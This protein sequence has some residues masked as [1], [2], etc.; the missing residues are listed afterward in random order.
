MKKII[1]AAALAL[2]SACSNV[3]TEANEEKVLNAKPVFFGS[4]GVYDQPVKGSEWVAWSTQAIPVNMQPEQHT[5]ELN[6]LMTSDGVPL[7][8]DASVVTQ[9]TD[10]VGLIKRFGTGWYDNNLRTEL[11]SYIRDAVKKHGMN[12]TAITSSAA[13]SIDA[14][15]SRRI[16]D[17]L[18]RTKF[19]V[20]LVRFTIGRANPPDS[21]K[22]QRI[23]TAAQ[24]QR[25]LT[26]K[27]AVVAE[28][29]RALSE[30]KRAKADQAYKEGLGLSS[31]Q[32]MEKLKLD[33]LGQV[34]GNK[35]CTFVQQGTPLILSR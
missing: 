33:T 16:E 15:V 20:R 32:Y 30:A 13:A 21:V 24:Q 4:G 28:E 9:V 27:S 8:F 1:A 7:D 31:D 2:V 26:L 25:V 18:A 22:N 6:D 23:A 11:L 14:E 19:P 5:F 12:E 34:C 3:T 29:Q 35:N 17:Y 10:S